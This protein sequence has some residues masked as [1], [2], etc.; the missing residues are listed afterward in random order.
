MSVSNIPTEPQ[1]QARTDP[2]LKCYAQPHHGPIKV[3]VPPV[4]LLF[5]LSQNVPPVLLSVTAVPDFS[6]LWSIT[7]PILL[8]DHPR[9]LTP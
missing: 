9:I 1:L 5:F 7:L 8:Y 2:Y 3:S 6:E 4:Y